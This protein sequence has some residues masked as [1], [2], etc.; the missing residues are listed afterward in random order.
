[1]TSQRKKYSKISTSFY[2]LEY[3]GLCFMKDGQN[4]CLEKTTQKAIEEV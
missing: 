4:V 1:M 3:V 2:A